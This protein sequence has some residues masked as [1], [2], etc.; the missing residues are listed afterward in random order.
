MMGATPTV[1]AAASATAET[2]LLP[3][4][5]RRDD[6]DPTIFSTETDILQRRWPLILVMAP[7]S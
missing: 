7:P 4:R 3:L 6:A 5:T 1:E 2:F